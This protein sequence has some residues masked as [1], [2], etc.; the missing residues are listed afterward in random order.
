MPHKG[1]DGSISSYSAVLVQ[2][3]N[4]PLDDLI[5]AQLAKEREL[6]QR[7]VLALAAAKATL[8]AALKKAATSLSLSSAINR[9]RSGRMLGKA[10]RDYSDEVT[11]AAPPVLVD[12][13]SEFAD[14]S[15]KGLKRWKGIKEQFASTAIFTE[16]EREAIMRHHA[17]YLRK[18]F[19]ITEAQRAKSALNEAY[20]LYRS[21]QDQAIRDR[22]M[23][24][25]VWNKMQARM[26]LDQSYWRNYV[27]NSLTTARSYAYLKTYDQMPGVVGYRLIAVL[28]SATTPLCRELHN[29]VF[30]LEPALER[31]E[32]MFTATSIEQIQNI[33]PFIHHGKGNTHYVAQGG[34][35][36]PVDIKDTRSLM[37]AGAM[38]PPFH[39]GCRTIMEPVYGLLDWEKIE[40][41]DFGDKPEKRDKEM[42]SLAK[43]EMIQD[44]VEF[45]KEL[46]NLEK[47]EVF[48]VFKDGRQVF[49]T[50]SYSKS[51]INFNFNQA[52]AMSDAQVIHNHLK[53]YP[54]QLSDAD[55]VTALTSN[56]LSVGAVSVYSGVKMMHILSRSDNSPNWGQ[57]LPALTI[58]SKPFSTE[59]FGEMIQK[60]N[61]LRYNSKTNEFL[62]EEIVK[63]SKGETTNRQIAEA[64]LEFS[65]NFIQKEINGEFTSFSL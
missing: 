28:D 11:A 25:H 21:E 64:F 18:H 35:N 47:I 56:T 61:T 51:E 33:R 42:A 5:K 57:L 14:S 7:I 23:A 2:R 39:H 58:G 4:D 54:P 62:A 13:Q 49:V 40:A 44:P 15:L 60:V 1:L 16:A 41:L 37:R 43:L 36:V 48:G 20:S 46:T 17:L 31:M 22:L 8:G 32:S 34:L 45:A 38:T 19:S 63:Y 6:L 53:G 9:F 50:S 29:R 24:D 3:E 12:G 55:I 65:Q 59:E 30:P 26:N 10:W 52:L 27:T